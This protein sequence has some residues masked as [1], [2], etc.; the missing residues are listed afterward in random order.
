MHVAHRLP[1][2]LAVAAQQAT[3]GGMPNSPLTPSSTLTLVLLLCQLSPAA[4]ALRHNL[5]G[6]AIVKSRVREVVEEGG[7]TWEKDRCN[8]RFFQEAR[9]DG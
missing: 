6:G 7:V 5:S 3:T 2:V 4:T 1:Q 8:T 9:R